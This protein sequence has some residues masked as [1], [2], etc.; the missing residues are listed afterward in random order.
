[1]LFFALCVPV[2]ADLAAGQQAYNRGDYTTALNE[3]LPLAKQ[4]DAVAQA[5]LGAMYEDG[6]GVQQDDKEAARWY[7]LAADQGSALAQVNI[8]AMY[9]K[10]QGVA[11]DYNEALRWLRL[12][13]VQKGNPA[14]Q[15]AAQFNLAVMYRK[16]QGVQQDDKEAAKWYRLAADQGDADAQFNLGVMYRIAASRK[17]CLAFL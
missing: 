5:M 2:L 16:G 14:A 8:G 15:R 13:A 12:A 7:R 6:Q 4:G 1:M 17:R 10:G 3:F 9:L 11:Q